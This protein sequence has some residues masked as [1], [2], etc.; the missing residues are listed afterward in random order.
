MKR[1]LL[2]LFF[3]FVLN[4]CKNRIS[5]KSDFLLGQYQIDFSVI[6]NYNND[7]TSVL[8]LIKR[9]N[10]NNVELIVDKKKYYFKNC[11]VPFRK[12]EGVWEYR[13]VGID[14]DCYLFITQNE[15]SRNTPLL[16][17]N[18]NTKV[19]SNSIVLPFKKIRK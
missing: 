11:D 12:Y 16:S 15:N 13:K 19:G 8:T 3:G 4:S 2:V 18:I 1:S 17:F 5:C 14:G 10:W 6:L 7:D 9:N